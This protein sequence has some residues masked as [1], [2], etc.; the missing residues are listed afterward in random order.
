MS[1]IK[2][3][4]RNL[5]RNKR[6]TAITISSIFFAVLFAVVMRSFQLGSYSLMIR[7]A[8]EQYYGYIRVQHPDFTDDPSLENTFEI[9]PSLPVKISKVPNVKAVTARLETFAL[10]SSGNITKGVLV[11]GIEPEAEKQFSNPE[12]FLVRFTIPMAVWDSSDKKLALSDKVRKVLATHMGESFTDAAKL[13]SIFKD[14]PI[15]SMQLNQ[16]LHL[17]RVQGRFISNGDSGVVISSRLAKF[18]N[19]QV[20]DSLVLLSQGYQGASAAGIYPVV[21]IVRIPNPELDNRVVYMPLQMAQSFTNTHN[22]LSYMAINL[23]DVSDKALMATTDSVRKVLANSGLDVKTWQDLNRVLVQQIESDNQSGK[24]FLFLLY[25]VVFFGIF[26]TVIMMVHERMHEFGVLVAVGM[27]KVNLALTVLLELLMMALIGIALGYLVALPIIHYYHIH[28]I[29][30][31]G[32]M[33]K[34]MMDMG[35]EPLMPMA[36]FDFYVLWQGVSVIFMV[37][38]ACIYP[39]RKILKL[40]TVEAIKR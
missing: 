6:R 27:Q 18:L 5:W 22:L 29:K 3:A 37:S 28:P 21:G 8:I 11:L 40:K 2:M 9:D 16:I 25:F 34:M 4:Q 30:L 10:A 19:I 13:A 36:P 12:Q 32:E 14:Q 26:G 38:L 17:S 33:A 24:A 23:Q 31:T 1:Y 15:D 35:F 20:G 7:N 39:I